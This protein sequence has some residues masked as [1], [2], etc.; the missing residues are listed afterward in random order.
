LVHAPPVGTVPVPPSRAQ[1]PLVLHVA[2]DVHAWQLTPLRPHA[3]V[4]PPAW[5]TPMASQ[6]PAQFDGPHGSGRHCCA[7]QVRPA[8]QVVHVAPAAP[9]APFVVPFTHTLF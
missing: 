5:H 2:P 3:V 9:H 1:T 8:P 7:W 4:A 6:Q